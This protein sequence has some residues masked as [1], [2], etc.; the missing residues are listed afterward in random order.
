GK[1]AAE[2]IGQVAQ[3]LQNVRVQLTLERGHDRGAGIVDIRLPLL[4]PATQAIGLALQL[5]ILLALLQELAL[6]VTQLK[7]QAGLVR[8]L[9]DVGGDFKWYVA[10]Q[11]TSRG[12]NLVCDVTH[13]FRV[14]EP[15]TVRGHERVQLSSLQ[16]THSRDTAAN[17]SCDRGAGE[18]C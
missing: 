3:G 15:N 7:T 4:L 16:A 5:D 10:A 2:H 17:P 18:H 12:R 1:L 9:V 13:L 14:E 8:L 6:E 11:R